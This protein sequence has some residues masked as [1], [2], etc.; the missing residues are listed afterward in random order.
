MLAGLTPATLGAIRVDSTAFGAQI[1]EIPDQ[2]TIL[3]LAPVGRVQG[4]LVAP[5]DEPIRGVMVSA[6]SQVGGYPG[7]GQGGSAV[8]ACDERGRFEIP[9]IAAGMLTLIPE[10]DLERGTTLRSWPIGRIPVRAGRT[11]EV[12]IPLHPTVKVQGLVRE[13]K[14]ERPIAGVT[15]LWNGIFDGRNATVSGGFGNLPGSVQPRGDPR[16]AIPDR[17]SS[18]TPRPGTGGMRGK[19]L[20]FRAAS[21]NRYWPPP[22][23]RAASRS[24]ARSSTSA[25]SPSP[26]PRSRRSDRPNSHRCN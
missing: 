5:A 16:H 12:A 26:A 19:D 1:L 11:T 9:A 20:G 17:I 15:V 7:S 14:T 21:T 10:F 13:R 25:A 4:R 8:V 23:C 24:A 6:V 2:A 18:S 22:S 3:T